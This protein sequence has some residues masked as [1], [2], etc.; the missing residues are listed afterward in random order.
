M[1][2]AR[3][4]AFTFISLPAASQESLDAHPSQAALGYEASPGD[5]RFKDMNGDGVIDENDK[6]NIGDPIPASVMGL[7]FTLA[8]K[9]FD[10][11][12]YTYASVGNDIVRNY[13]RAQPNVNRLRTSLDRWTGAGT[14]DFEPRLTTAA[15]TNTIFSDYYV[16]N[17]SYFR[18]QRLQL[19]YTI[20]EETTKKIRIQMLKFFVAVSN[21]YTFTKYL[22]YDPAASSGA[23][24]GSGFDDGFY[25]PARTYTFG[26][27]L[28]I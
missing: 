13:E 25:P 27:S 1:A 4:I 9:G 19:G 14:S 23:P 21:L 8:Y 28:N 16:E 2:P 15:T 26:I 17:G 3:F 12:V 18:I 22:G 24:I 11:L 5:I 7:N 20:P 6:T 10:L